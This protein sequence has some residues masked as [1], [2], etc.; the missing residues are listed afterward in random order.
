MG[1]DPY[2]MPPGIARIAC[3]ILVIAHAQSPGVGAKLADAALTDTLA[4]ADQVPAIRHSIVHCGRYSAPPGWT[5]Y[6]QRGYRLDQRLAN[7]YTDTAKPGT[8]SILLRPDTPQVTREHIA[9]L[10]AGLSTADA[11]LGP[12]ADGDWWGLALRDANRGRALAGVPVST[13][14]TARWTIDAL[15]AEGHTVAFAPVLRDVAS[16]GDALAVAAECPPDSA[17]ATAVRHHLCE[18]AIAF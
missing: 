3:Q 15:R 11:V 9:M 7:A 1:D 18:P 12:A 8:A 13:V 4:A 10:Y 2:N 17:F 5:A 6:H 16:T 14:D